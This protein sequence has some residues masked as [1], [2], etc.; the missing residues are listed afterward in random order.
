MNTV[1]L[2]NLNNEKRHANLCIE[3]QQYFVRTVYDTDYVG[4]LVM[5]WL[6]VSSQAETQ[7][8]PLPAPGNA[9]ETRML[10]P[11]APRAIS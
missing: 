8:E 7:T 11:Y 3:P 6:V 10:S 2:S 9:M 1:P 4:Q 5:S